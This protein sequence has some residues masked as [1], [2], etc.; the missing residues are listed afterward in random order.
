MS[1]TDEDLSQVRDVV[2]SAIQELVLP[3][4]DEHDQRFEALDSR[5]ARLEADIKA[6]QI[7]MRQ[8]KSTLGKLDGRV[9]AL[10]FSRLLSA[11][12]SCARFA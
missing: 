6:T 12:S 7:D 2:V 4:F 9:E 3:R 10:R 8:L 1:L 5:L 11:R